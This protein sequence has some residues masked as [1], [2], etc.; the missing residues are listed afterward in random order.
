MTRPDLVVVM[1]GCVVRPSE[2]T[3]GSALIG[4]LALLMLVRGGGFEYNCIGWSCGV[5]MICLLFLRNT[6]PCWSLTTY[7]RGRTSACLHCL[8][9]PGR[10]LTLSP[11]SKGGRSL[12]VLS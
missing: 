7:D 12:A 4:G 5:A 10:I 3:E 9:L 11:G 8:S 1:L 6:V 2:I